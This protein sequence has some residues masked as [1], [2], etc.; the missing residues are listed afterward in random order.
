[1]PVL[2]RPLDRCNGPAGVVLLPVTVNL[3]CG[4][5]GLYTNKCRCAYWN[6]EETQQ[7]IDFGAAHKITP[8]D[9][10][11]IVEAMTVPDAGVD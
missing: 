7:S 6:E 9:V 10:E 4:F 5:C 3:I 2:N 1:M 11:A 8:A